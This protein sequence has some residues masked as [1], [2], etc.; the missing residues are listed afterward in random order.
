[1]P[2]ATRMRFSYLKEKN[3]GKFKCTTHD[4]T[5]H[6]CVIK[7]IAKRLLDASVIGH[8]SDY[9]IRVLTSNSMQIH[10]HKVLQ[11]KPVYLKEA[12]TM[13]HFGTPHPKHS[14]YIL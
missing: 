6:N 4:P 13:A 11:Q 9:N 14:Q 5:K 12:A 1:M 3:K 10:D 2:P 8:V 7:R